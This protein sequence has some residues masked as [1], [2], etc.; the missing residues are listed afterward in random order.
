VLALAVVVLQS[1]AVDDGV[2]LVERA[3]DALRAAV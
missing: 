1:V 3:A 2:E